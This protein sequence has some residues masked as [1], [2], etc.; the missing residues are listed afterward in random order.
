MTTAARQGTRR[1]ETIVYA[2]G[3]AVPARRAARR[4]PMNSVTTFPSEGDA[5]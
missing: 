4:D 2:A 1:H 5:L 3:I